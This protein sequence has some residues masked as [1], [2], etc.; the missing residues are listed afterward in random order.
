[1]SGGNDEAQSGTL[2]DRRVENQSEEMESEESEQDNDDED[3]D[4]SG[5]SESKRITALSAGVEKY[6]RHKETERDQISPVSE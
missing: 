2:D 4:S 5:L 1:M 3:T 6:T